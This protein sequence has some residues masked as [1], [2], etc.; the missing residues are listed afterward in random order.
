MKRLVNFSAVYSGA[1]IELLDAYGAVMPQFAPI[2]LAANAPISA[3]LEPNASYP[4]RTF[5]RLRATGKSD[6]LFI[7]PSLDENETI[8]FDQL[9]DFKSSAGW[10]AFDGDKKF[11]EF[12]SSFFERFEG[13]IRGVGSLRDYEGSFFQDFCRAEN[14]EIIRDDLTALDNRLF[15]LAGGNEPNYPPYAP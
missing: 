11:D 13:Q 12:A 10:D 3:Q 7:A 2:T 9:T 15:A 14:G 6:A 5:Y 1:T 4:K 8:D